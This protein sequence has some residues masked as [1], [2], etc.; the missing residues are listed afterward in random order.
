MQATEGKILP[1]EGGFFEQS[2]KLI[3]DISTISTAY[4]II[5]QHLDLEEKENGNA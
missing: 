5:K 1:N 4:Q 3:T 2:D